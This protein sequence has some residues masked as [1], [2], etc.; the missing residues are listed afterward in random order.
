MSA[1]DDAIGAVA[2]LPATTWAVLGILSF[3]SALSGYDVKRWADQ[4][5]AFFYWAPSQSQIY[6]ELRRLESL[7]LATSLIEQTHAAKSR[8]VY[9]ITP[10]GGRRSRRGPTSWSRT[11]S[12]S[13]TP[14]SCACGRRTM[15]TWVACGASCSP[16]GRSPR[17]GRM[18]QRRTR[19][20]RPARL[21]GASPGSRWNGRSASIATRR[22]ASIGSSIASRASAESSPCRR[23][24]RRSP[25]RRRVSAR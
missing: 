4:S 24:R 5:L 18:P 17:S 14:T 19:R 12:C 13:S 8:R 9:E 2:D 16:I 22:R 10:S 6:G 21:R 20:R 25:R 7:G 1:A 11:R 23:V 3:D 15:E